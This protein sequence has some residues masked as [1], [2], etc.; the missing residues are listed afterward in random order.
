MKNLVLKNMLKGSVFPVI[1][2]INKLIPKSDKRVLLHI[3]SKRLV[4]SLGPIKDYLVENGYDKKYNISYGYLDIER[5][6]DANWVKKL[7][8]IRS[9]LIFMRAKHVFYTS[10]QIPIKPSKSQIVIHVQHGNADFKPV[11]KLANIDNGDE[12]F[13]TYMIAPS[14]LYVPI[15]AKEYECSEECIKVAGDPMTDALLKAPKNVYDF[16]SFKK[17]LIW[18]PTFRQ[19]DLMGYK[20]SD[21][22]TLVPLFDGE[23][24]QSLNN[25]LAEYNIRLI[26]KLHPIQTTPVNMQRHFSHLSVYSHDEFVESKY[27]ILTLMANSDG[28]IGDYSSISMQYLL[29]DKPQAFVVPDI[30]DYGSN[31]GFVFEH[32]EDYMG[33]HII[34]T[35]DEFIQFIK[36]FAEDNDLYRDKRHWVCKQVYKYKDA[37]SCA[38]IIKLSE[39]CI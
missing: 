20:D 2:F 27:D 22:N 8:M 16:S 35:K 29:T 25:L 11:G 28:M 31:R 12:F 23:D 15:M 10:G 30:D 36:D 21:L 3:P 5:L 18:T 38:R 39:M 32:P 17:V 14:Q 1:S 34:K 9:M 4:Y 7:A 37:N 19:S 6:G 13:F 24:Y 33:G 26:V